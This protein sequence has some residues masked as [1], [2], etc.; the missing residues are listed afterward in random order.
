MQYREFG[1]LG[2][3]VSTFGM[4]CMRLP[5]KKLEGGK[6]EY[7]QIDEKEAIAMVRYAAD[8]GVNYFDTAYA[9]HDGNS[10]KVLG[11]ALKGGY[12]EKVKLATKLPVW[13]VEKYEDFDKILDEQL[14][15]L[16][17]D[18]V[19]FYLLHSLSADSWKKAKRLGALEFLDRAVESGKIKHPGFSFHDRVEIFRNIIDSYDR[20]S[21][22]QVQY[23][24]LD[25]H[26]QAG[27]E[28]IKYAAS[29]GIPVV[30]M[31]PLRGGRLVNGISADIKAVWDKTDIKRSPAEWAFRWVCNHPEVTVILSGVSTMEQLKDNIRIFENALPGSMT[32][33]ELAI[34][35]EVQ[36]CYKSKIKVGCTGCR[37]C[38]PCPSG[39]QID[40]TFSLYDTAMLF[41]NLAGNRERYKKEYIDKGKDAT[42]CVE[43]GH[44]ESVCPQHIPIIEKLKEAHKVLS[45]A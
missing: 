4:G 30:I 28:G 18:S 34:V 32:D 37:Y 24:I 35:K 6:T 14:K 2:F 40:S 45:G 16:E 29:K 22:C 15:R 20:W 36:E 44:C 39:V 38:M 31:E 12:R 13:K 43:C 8:H 23:N 9:Y 7:G 27:I 5:L 33:K 10:E 25:E 19:D 21:M 26:A 3:K 1:K 17:V 42:L 41:D 11:K